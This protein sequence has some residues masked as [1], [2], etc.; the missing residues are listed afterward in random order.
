MSNKPTDLGSIAEA[1]AKL[2]EELRKL[3]KQEVELRQQQASKAYERVM[4]LLQEFATHFSAKQKADI[5]G[6]VAA[7]P[8]RAKPRLPSRK[9]SP[10]IGCRIPAKPGPAAAARRAPFPRG[11][12]PLPIKSGKQTIPARNSPSIRG[13]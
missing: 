2:T 12:A 3:E 4:G 1:K 7:M 13:D 5:A 9:S 10:S 6:L 11:R 8:R